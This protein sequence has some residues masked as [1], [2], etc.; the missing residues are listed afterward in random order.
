MILKTLKL[1]NI[2]SYKD[3]TIEFPAGTTLFE[4]DIGSGKSTILM[5]IEFALFGL[6]SEKGG[7]LLRKGE[8]KGSVSLTFSVNDQDYTVTRRL[9]GRGAGGVQ[10]D[11]EGI[12]E[13][14]QGDYHLSASELKA[15]I[16]QVLG[17]NEPPDPKAQSIIYR[18]AVFTPQEEMK[19][20]IFAPPDSRLQ[21]LRKALHIEDYKI[22]ASNANLV[23]TA[24]IKR[25]S[26]L[27]SAASD[28]ETIQT[29]IKRRED[30]I[31]QYIELLNTANEHE[32]SEAEALSRLREELEKH[33]AQQVQLNEI[34]RQIK[35]LERQLSERTALLD[36]FNRDMQA[37]ERRRKEIA[38]CIEAF[39]RKISP[40]EKTVEELRG[41][42]AE[43]EHE[44]R[45]L[46]R[47]ETQ[48]D[49]KMEDYLAIEADGKCPTCDRPADSEEFKGKIDS[50]QKEKADASRRVT[51]CEASLKTAKNLLESLQEYEKE[52]REFLKCKTDLE[53]LEKEATDNSETIGFLKTG[54]EELEKTLEDC[55][56]ES[57]KLQDVITTISNLNYRIRSADN[58]L[59]GT[60]AR[61]VELATKI[62][63]LSQSI[64]ED[65][66]RV[67]Q[68]IE[69][70]KRS[71]KLKE[72]ET[73][74][75]SFFIPTLNLI[76]KHILANANQEF[77][78]HFQ[79]WFSLLVED[80]GK[81]ARADETFTPIVEQDGYE[82]D[83][84][85]LSGGEKTSVALAYRLALNAIV[86]RASTSMKSNLLI[87]DEPTDGFSKEQLSRVKDILD[88]LECPQ[89]I[90]VSHERE[91]ESFADQIFNITKTQGVSQIERR[92][93]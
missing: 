30:E 68:K 4:G 20:I 46:R 91:L 22:A 84:H 45:K 39:E 40:T 11:R 87:L 19:G 55:R 93:A 42:I 92:R 27:R 70:K 54:I 79:R 25:A 31:K 37:R 43:L 74:L 16:L 24:L 1:A 14:P 90:I 85:Y 64:K 77:N 21:T 57:S 52:R 83:I 63:D 61:V 51:E 76:E 58:T 75:D 12:L 50:K 66:S 26:E 36:R 9:V 67:E 71:E 88:E 17:F 3:E 23:Q 72:Y 86:Q 69:F 33:Q 34:N 53:R 32:A 89:V 7:A 29:S 73:W 59:Q 2:R 10:Q 41:E 47:T 28:L 78:T 49:A 60:R 65:N 8:P 56:E 82:Q 15:K 35:P 62:S 44:E 48:I 5:S 13:T 6:G 38:S 81:T 80:V 18:Y